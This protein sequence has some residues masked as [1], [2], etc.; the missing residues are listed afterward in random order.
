MIYN[1]DFSLYRQFLN[2]FDAAGIE[3]QIAVRSGQWDFLAAMVKAGIGLA[4]L[5]EPLCR[6]LDSRRML[7]LP[8]IPQML[9]Q[10]G[11][12]W[13]QNSYLSHGA[14]AWIVACRERWL[15]SERLRAAQQKTRLPHA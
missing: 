8:L 9:W 6:R 4:V 15:P 13:H 10:L 1:E 2:T 7:W 11:L 5:P 14:Q 12:I 3:P